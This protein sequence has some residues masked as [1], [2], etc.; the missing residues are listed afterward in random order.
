M[1]S[2]SG[3]Y[4]QRPGMMSSPKRPEAVQPVPEEYEGVNF[5]YRGIENHGVEPTKGVDPE[6]YYDHDKWDAGPDDIPSLPAEKEPDPIPVKIM[7]ASGRER[8]NFR[9]AKTA[10]NTITPQQLMGRNDRRNMVRIRVPG[11]SATGAVFG[12]DPGVNELTGYTVAVGSE[13]EFRTTEAIYV[14]PQDT[15][16]IAT[17]MT[18]ETF[19]VE[20]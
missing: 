5:P 3:N 19:S 1:G 20:L 10:F 4:R 9:T 6:N 7:N 18:L 12:P 14:L 8:F 13:I 15:S 2:Y 16:K 17:V 11:S